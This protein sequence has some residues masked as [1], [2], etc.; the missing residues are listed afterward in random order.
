MSM[1]AGVAVG[2]GV[3]AA[4]NQLR[5]NMCKRKPK[6][7]SGERESARYVQHTF[8]HTHTSMLVCCE[9]EN[10][11]DPQIS[12]QFSLSVCASSASCILVLNLQY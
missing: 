6:L 7:E 11:C 10:Q 1:S 5:Q 12:M 2:G 9:R 3:D 4:L 8:M